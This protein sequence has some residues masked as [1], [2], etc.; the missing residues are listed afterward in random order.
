MVVRR[1]TRWGI[2]SC[3]W[4]YRTA[5]ISLDIPDNSAKLSRDKMYESK[6][7]YIGTLFISEFLLSLPY[8][9]FASDISGDNCN[10]RNRIIVPPTCYL[11]SL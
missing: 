6:D 9:I 1:L 2:Y 10:Y 7:L 11:G 8:K 5:Y 3:H 4:I